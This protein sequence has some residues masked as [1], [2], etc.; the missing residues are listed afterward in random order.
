V[1][2]LGLALEDRAHQLGQARVD[3]DDLLEFVEHEQ[4]LALAVGGELA[5]ELEQP[6]DRGVDVLAALADVE[7]ER[8]AP[9]CGSTVIVGRTWRSPN[10]R[11]RSF[12]RSNG[13][14]M[15]SWIVRAS[16]SA[17]IAAFGPS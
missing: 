6:P 17:K 9:D 12:A 7:G 2:D 11:R 13:D 16:R 14:A 8:R 4:D 1:R 5:R 10:T 15:S 3:L